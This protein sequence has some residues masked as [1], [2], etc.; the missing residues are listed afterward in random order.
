MSWTSFGVNPVL[1]RVGPEDH[2]IYW[3]VIVV[4]L[5][6]SLQKVENMNALNVSDPLD[7]GI[8]ERCEKNQGATVAEILR[9]LRAVSDLSDVGLRKR[10]YSLADAGFLRLERTR[11]GRILVYVEPGA[12]NMGLATIHAASEELPA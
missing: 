3:G 12:D 2:T 8:L 5:R 1:I 6:F 4:A 7:C 10:L 11:Q 9:P